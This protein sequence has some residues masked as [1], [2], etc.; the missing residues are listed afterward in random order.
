MES[1]TA[2]DPSPV[3]PK[4]EINPLFAGIAVILSMM[5]AASGYFGWRSVKL[6][7]D[8]QR[9]DAEVEGLMAE[10]EQQGQQ[11]NRDKAALAAS[12]QE[13]ERLQAEMA[14]IQTQWAEKQKEWE[15]RDAEQLQ[16]LQRSFEALASVV[17]DSGSALDYLKEM[18]AKVRKGESL[19]KQEMEELKVL[20]K[21]LAYLQAQ[22]ER[23]LDE[24][25]ALQE[26]IGKELE[27]STSAAP[28]EEY[29][30]LRAMFDWK[31][32]ERQK[33]EKAALLKEQGRREALEDTQQELGTRY[34]NAQREM[35]AVKKQFGEHMKKLDLLVANEQT[36]AADM[37][38]FFE[39]SSEVIKIHQRVMNIHAEPVPASQTPVMSGA[40]VI[41]P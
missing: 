7:R 17:N 18:E 32:R 41:K 27:S 40:E 28:S 12:H 22:Y 19:G 39:V 31:Y 36:N 33:A 11:A 2:I 24:F 6:E 37:T 10:L 29:K 23:P 16:R 30:F 3:A 13:V 4:R 8:N 20:G 25:R 21:G 26:S 1:N 38:S 15:R 34:A 14:R 35:A 5:L 9:L